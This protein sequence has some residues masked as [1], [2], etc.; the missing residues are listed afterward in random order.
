MGFVFFNGD[1]VPTALGVCMGLY[2]HGGSDPTW[3]AAISIF[4]SSLLNGLYADFITY[5]Q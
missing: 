1:S 4:F 3:R 2:F 5:I